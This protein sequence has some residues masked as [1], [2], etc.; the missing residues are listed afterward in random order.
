MSIP[1]VSPILKRDDDLGMAEAFGRDPVLEALVR[2][3]VTEHE[4][5]TIVETGTWRGYTTR[6]FAEFVANVFTIESDPSLWHLA[7]A[8]LVDK[9][10]VTLF[11]GRSQSLLRNLIPALLKPALYYLDAHWENDWPILQE[12]D[13]IA[14]LDARCCIIIHDCKVPTC[15]GLGFDSYNGQELTLEFVRPMLDRLRFPWRH[16]FNDDSAQGHRRGALFIVPD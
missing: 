10:N 3:V 8:T 13:A 11:Q 1:F 16:Y 7:T 6:R 15:P 5:R 4:I 14:E 2:Q 12:L 9:P